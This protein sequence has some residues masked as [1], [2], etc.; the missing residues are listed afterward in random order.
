MEVGTET[1][2]KRGLGE[3]LFPQKTVAPVKGSG[4][5][6]IARPPMNVHNGLNEIMVA[7]EI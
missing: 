4:V 2:T 1:P 6:V 3:V 5:S 7:C